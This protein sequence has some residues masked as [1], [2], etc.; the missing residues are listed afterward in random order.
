VRERERE[1]ER[2]RDRDR[3]RD[4]DRETEKENLCSPDIFMAN[5]FLMNEVL[6]FT[7]PLL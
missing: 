1:R 6:W 2:E 5:V 4:R 3:D 7:L